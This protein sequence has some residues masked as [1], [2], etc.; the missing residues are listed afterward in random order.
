MFKRVVSAFFGIWSIT[1]PITAKADSSGPTTNEQW[2]VYQRSA[3]DDKRLV[4]IVRTGNTEVDRLLKNGRA[5]VI[6][7]R[8]DPENVNEVGMPQ[9][10]DRLYQLEEDPAL[11]TAEIIHV[12]SVTGQGSRRMF[13]LHRDPLDF[14][15][16]LQKVHVPGFVCSASEVLDRPAMI[17]LV[18]P[19]AL[20][21]QLS[22]DQSVIANLEKNGDD[23]HL[24]RKTDFWFY[25]QKGALVSLA[26]DLKAHGFSIDHWMSEPTG[27]V[28][29]REIPVDLKS[30]QT[31]TP[32]LVSAA[33]AS[34]VEYDGWET[35]V[36]SRDAARP[37]DH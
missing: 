34:K 2:M 13:I 27:L 6:V 19:T 29:T 31:I 15:A 30:F 28:L 7:C 22:G 12:A 14:G 9:G 17:N 24:S 36:L 16:I 8:A 4:V 35:L 37:M 20:E 11:N 23:G 1:Q 10:T 25:G 5:T 18:T 33:E 21:R 32:V 3:F 26:T